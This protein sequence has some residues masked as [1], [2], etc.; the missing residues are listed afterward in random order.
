MIFYVNCNSLAPVHIYQYLHFMQSTVKYIPK[1]RRAKYLVHLNVSLLHRHRGHRHN[2]TLI[3]AGSKE[4]TTRMM[5]GSSLHIV[6]VLVTT[7]L[8]NITSLI[9]PHKVQIN[10][11]SA[12]AITLTKKIDWR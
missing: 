9:L 1:V 3:C 8:I 12:S 10:T 6:N 7:C 4:I 2:V 11:L 5:S